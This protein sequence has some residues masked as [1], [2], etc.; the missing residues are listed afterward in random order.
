MDLISKI[1]PTTTVLTPNLRLSVVLQK[2]YQEHQVAS[3]KTCWPT[4]AIIEISTWLQ[5]T[6]RDYTAAH[7]E[8][9]PLILTANQEHILWEEILRESSESAL[10]QLSNTAELAKSAWNLLKQWRV[11]IDHP[12]LQATDDSQIFQKWATQF[13]E[14]C[15]QHQWLD[16]QSIPDRVTE[17]IAAGAITPPARLLL[18]GFVELTPQQQFFLETCRQ[19]GTEVIEIADTDNPHPAHRISLHDTATEMLTMARWA[20]AAYDQSVDAKIGCVIPNL[21]DARE[22]IIAIFSEVFAEPGTY[23]LDHTRLPFNISAGRRLSDYPVIHAALQL[24]GVNKHKIPLQT[25]SHILHSPFIGGAER[26]QAGRAKLDV[27]L[28][29]DNLATLTLPEL[30]QHPATQRCPDFTKRVQR[31][32]DAVPGTALRLPVSEW[33]VHF[34]Q[35]LTL[36]GWPGERTL[37]SPE[38]QTVKAWL[39][40]LGEYSR[41]DRVLGAVPASTALHY[42]TYLAAKLI[43]Q[44]QSPE[45]RVQ[46]LGPLE[47]AALPFEHLWVM[48]LD[49]AAWPQAPKPNPFIP[50]RLQKQL[51]MPRATAER[52]LIYANQI[53]AQFKANSNNIIF[54]HAEHEDDTELRV[55]PLL[56]DLPELTLE[57]LTLAA[58]TAPA[59]TLFDSRET[60]LIQDEIAPA[61]G[62]TETV[63]GGTRI[64]KNQALC[65]FKAFAELRLHAGKIEPTTAGLRQTERG[66]IVHLALEKLWLELQDQTQLLALS[67]P[68]LQERI[69]TSVSLAMREVTKTTHNNKRYLALESQRLQ[70]LLTD[71]FELEKARPYF[72]IDS[73]EK[74][75]ETQFATIPLRVRADRIDRLAN[76]RL[77]IIDYKTGDTHPG[78]DWF[79]DRPNEPQLPLYCVLEPTAPAGI[80]FAQIR[81]E[82]MKWKGISDIPLGINTVKTIAEDKNSECTTWPEQIAHW[83]TVLAKLAADFC[84]GDAHVDPKE[85]EKTCEYCHLQTLCRINETITES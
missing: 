13:Q 82:E 19:Q 8:R 21:E 30:A 2:Q 52:E 32:L 17:K 71:W 27:A 33:V 47:A 80:L 23:T 63:K 79:D 15:Q 78:N 76:G 57:N 42:L 48:G 28:R 34:N 49:D 7:I 11:A 31:Y 44:P 59:Q 55:S 58:F 72:A 18:V 62:S 41:Y 84:Q 4:A 25:I 68:E 40:L 66:E 1:T 65:P 6:W 24:L 69:Q 64:F 81:P 3:G 75:Q 16:M 12:G 77:V 5:K 14:R 29:K 74:E 56:K 10:L 53:T 73:L 67:A 38:Y 60:E 35:Q 51:H 70:K 43:F 50:Q 61:I 46:I 45:A 36:W 26:E 54:S 83:Q 22:R 37:D 85:P 39:K 9:Y 20:K